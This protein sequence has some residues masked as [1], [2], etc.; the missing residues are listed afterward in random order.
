[1]DTEVFFPLDGDVLGVARAK[2]VCAAC[3]VRAACL[4]FALSTD[5]AREFGI[6]G[7]TT[8]AERDRLLRRTG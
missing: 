8:G 5:D 3:P 1:M 2:A 4:E 7:G 6:Y